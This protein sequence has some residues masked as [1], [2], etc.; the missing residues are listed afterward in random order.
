MTSARISTILDE[1]RA[2]EA[3]IQQSLDGLRGQMK[4]A[5]TQLAQIR[6]STIVIEGEA[7]KRDSDEKAD[8]DKRR[9]CRGDSARPASQ[10]LC[11]RR[12]A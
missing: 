1:L 6:K 4:T 11:N 8:C 5:E 12:R 3:D 7:A 10:R 2:E 9:S